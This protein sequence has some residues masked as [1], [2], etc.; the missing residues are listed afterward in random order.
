[1]IFLAETNFILDVALEQDTNCEY[2]KDLADEE[3]I[4]M[5]I[6]EYAIAEAEGA[7]VQKLLNRLKALEPALSA[8]RQFSRS[9]YH[10]LDG[11]IRGVEQVIGNVKTNEIPLVVE[12]ISKIRQLATTIPLTSEILVQVKL[13]EA[14]QIPP[15]KK[16][17]ICIYES[18]LKFASE[19]KD[20]GL[21]F[22]FL[23]RDRKDFDYP[24]IHAE[25]QALGV[26]L[27]FS[28]GD[29]VRRIRE[30]LELE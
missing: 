13:R 27:F 4:Q 7:G 24:Q 11:L 19:N 8:L 20:S 5:A 3:Q 26:E 12:K 29:C 9:A 1:V 15:F 25:L 23:N 30:L 28:A 22:V 14:K 21:N 2:L 10:D 16:S 6:P 18:I 17:D